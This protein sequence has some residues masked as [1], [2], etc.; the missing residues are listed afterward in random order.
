MPGRTA[1]VFYKSLPFGAD[2]DTMLLAVAATQM[3]MEPFLKLVREHDIDCLSLVAGVGP[4]ETAVT[5]GRFLAEYRFQVTGLVQFGVAGAYI[6]PEEDGQ[7]PLLSVCLAEHEVMGDLGI[8][9]PESVEYLPEDLVGS[10]TFPLQSALLSRAVEVLRV[11]Q[12]SCI[13]GAFITVNS[14]SGT[15]ARGEMLRQQWGGLCENMEGAA[16]AR[17][18]REYGLPLVEIR[19]ISNLVE[20]RNLQNWQLHQ[21]C[22]RS[23]EIAA[24]LVKE[25]T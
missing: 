10:M 18:C 4:M 24:L 20:D 16:V 21:A 11:N 9:F 3:E 2:V 6:T 19:V 8:C 14:T 13:L 22:R 5:L 25:L 17:L 15:L 23:G 7:L 1:H 12:I